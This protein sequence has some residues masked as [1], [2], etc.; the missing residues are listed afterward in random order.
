[1]LLFHGIYARMYSLFLFLSTLSYLAL[2][3]AL[4]RGGR[5]WI[6]WAIVMLLAIAA[7]PYGALVLGSQGLYVLVHAPPAFGRRSRRSRPSSSSRSRSGG[8]A[9]CS[10]TA[11]TSASGAAAGSSAPR[12]EVFAYLWHVAGDS[13]AGYTGVTRRRA[14]AS[15]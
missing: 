3:R 8:A 5:A 7:H 9:S 2:L 6:L 15:P 13:S 10:R 14:R 12:G 1:M 4:D 11:S